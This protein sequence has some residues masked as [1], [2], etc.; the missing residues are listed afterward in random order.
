MTPIIMEIIRQKKVT[1]AVILSLFLLNAALMVL[2]SY[3]QSSALAA[4]QIKWSDLRR[5]NASAGHVDSSALYRQGLSDL[6]KLKT[7]I[8]AKHE[9]AR[10]LSELL[11]AASVSG[12]TVGSISYK[13]TAIKEEGL[14]SY[15]LSFPVAGGYAAIKSYLADLQNNS[16]LLVV[17]NIVFSNTDPFVEKVVMDLHLTVYLQGGV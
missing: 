5:K 11:E 10:V 17:D 12:V 14:L 13:P 4:A 9:F 3:Y 8:P 7:S 1:L 15:Q 6:E 16:G 2:T